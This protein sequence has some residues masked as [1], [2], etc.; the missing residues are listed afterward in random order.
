LEQLCSDATEK[1]II[2]RI[3]LR[4]DKKTGKTSPSLA[5][6]RSVY[7][8]AIRRNREVYLGSVNST[9]MPDDIPAAVKLRATMV[10]TD[11]EVWELKAYLRSNVPAPRDPLEGLK[12]LPA[13]MRQAGIELERRAADLKNLGI[14]PKDS[15]APYLDAAEEAWKSLFK[16][17]QAA[18]LKRTVRRPKRPECEV[19]LSKT[20]G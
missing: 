5:L 19:P 18:G 11:G 17:A 13:R 7:N 15:I 12:G 6:V 8:P 20:R 1:A 2:V 10:L 4:K 9:T 16:A 14:G 3:R